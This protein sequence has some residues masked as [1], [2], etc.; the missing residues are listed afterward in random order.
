[1][2]IGGEVCWG[3]GRAFSEG[4]DVEGDGRT[5]SEGKVGIGDEGVVPEGDGQHRRGRLVPEMRGPC[6]GVVISAGGGWSVS[7]S[8]VGV[9]GGGGCRRGSSLGRLY[10]IYKRQGSSPGGLSKHLFYVNVR[11]ALL[12]ACKN[13]QS[14]VQG[15]G[16]L[17]GGW[18][19]VHFHV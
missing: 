13:V 18:R 12:E 19:K 11:E 2:F 14:S 8:K 6:R 4:D 5:A 7:D 3:D 17:S 1:M 10:E 16:A 15:K 9:R